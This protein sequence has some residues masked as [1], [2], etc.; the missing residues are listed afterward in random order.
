MKNMH[1]MIAIVLGLALGACGGSGADSEAPGNTASDT[2][3]AS[4][5]GGQL[6][7]APDIGNWTIPVPSIASSTVPL[8]DMKQ[9]GSRLYYISAAHGSDQTGELYFWNG[10]HI[11]DAHG[12]STDASGRAYGTD[13]M[14]PSAAVHAFKRWAY[15][16][17]RADATKDYGTP[18][19]VGGAGYGA[20]GGFPDWWLFA[21]G[22]TF[23][24]SQDL[25][26]FEHETHP[27]TT[28]VNSSLAVPGGRSATE[29]QVVAAYGDV[30][31]PRPRFIHPMLGFVSS[32]QKTYNPPLKNVAYLSLHFDGHDRITPGTYAGITLLSQTA[33]ATGILFEDVWL[34]AATVNI[35]GA[36]GAAVKLRRVLLTDNYSTDGSHVEGLYYQ[37]SPEGQLRIEE[38][39]LLRNGFSRGDPKLMSWPPSSTQPGSPYWDIYNR[40]MYINGQT[41]MMQS[42]FFDSVSMMGTSGDQFRTGMRVE[43]NFFYQGYVA[44]GASGGHPDTDGPTGTIVDNVLQ[45]FVGTGTT[46][47]RGHPGWGFQLGSGAY[48]VEVSGNIVTSAQSAPAVYAFQLNPLGWYCYDFSFHYPTR[49]NKVHDNVFD[50]AGAAAAVTIEDG[51]SGEETLGC[52]HW[53]Y[54]GVTGNE[55][56]RNVMIDSTLKESVYAPKGAAVGTTND[57][58]F[59]S[60]RMFAS[61]TTAAQ[62]LGWSAPERTL[63]TYLLSRG[64]AVSSADGFPEYFTLATAQRRGQWQPD[65]TGRALVEYVRTGFGKPTFAP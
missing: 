32:Y 33:A 11:I 43:R 46:D 54:P 1:G 60:N 53:A 38:S 58:V 2:A 39:I 61:R 64:V 47:N 10:S 37:G 40:N 22:E 45:R 12:S 26:S 57:T 59:S 42:G 49:Q 20:R 25:L 16:G 62:A 7:T 52:A 9:P 15:V 6:C 35:G 48:Q 36:N 41:A 56:A 34:D 51:V 4:S 44:M 5:I 18:G 28:S 50:A 30:C 65:W 19:L 17:P 21:R 24:L 3:T 8:L 31:R 29:P 14:N 13:P 27:D 63:K 23:D 55:V